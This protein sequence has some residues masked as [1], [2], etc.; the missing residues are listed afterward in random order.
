MLTFLAI[1]HVFIGIALVVF[2]LLQDPKDGAAGVFGGGSSSKS[3][4]GASGASNFLT[5]TTK[6]LSVAFCVSCLVLTTLTT[7]HATSVLDDATAAPAT[8][9]ATGA[10]PAAPATTNAPVAAPAAPATTAP[11]APNTPKHE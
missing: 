11:A 10:A 7:K 4:F 9:P 1:L 8:A 3:F 2:V 6:W 5:T